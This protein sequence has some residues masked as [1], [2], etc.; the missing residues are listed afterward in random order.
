MGRSAVVHHFDIIILGKVGRYDSSLIVGAP[1]NYHCFCQRGK[2]AHGGILVLI[3][4]GIHASWV[5]CSLLNIC[6][7]DLHLDKSIRI[8]AIYAPKSKSWKLLDISCLFASHC[9]IMDD[10]NVDLEKD[11]DKSERFTHHFDQTKL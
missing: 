11:R 8:I 6:S 9:V 2:N 7:I 3:S 1:P 10:F 4:M 5:N